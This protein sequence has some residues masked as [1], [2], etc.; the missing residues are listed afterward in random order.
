MRVPDPAPRPIPADEALQLRLRALLSDCATLG[1]ALDRVYRIGV[2]RDLL[3]PVCR[4]DRDRLAGRCD[5]HPDG[6]PQ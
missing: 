1:E 4:W 3:R 5:H 6:C 2:V